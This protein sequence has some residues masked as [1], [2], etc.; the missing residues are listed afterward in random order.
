ML[1]RCGA[2]AGRTTR[3]S[4]TLAHSRALCS[5]DTAEGGGRCTFGIP[6]ASSRS[7]RFFAP[8]PAAVA[9]AYLSPG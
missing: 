1:S 4:T 2:P 9:A 3:P 8:Q 7:A 5:V 6:N